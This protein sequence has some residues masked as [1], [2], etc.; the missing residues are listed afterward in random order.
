MVDPLVAEPG[1]LV[2][3]E[4][5]AGNLDERFRDRLGHRTQARGEPAGKNRDRKA[6]AKRTFVPSK[7]KRNR[8]SSRPALAIAARSRR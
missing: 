7:S 8:T 4:R 1:E 2:L 5:P 3:D 6:H